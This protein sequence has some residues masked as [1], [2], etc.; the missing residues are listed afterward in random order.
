[1]D[2][3][4]HQASA[5]RAVANVPPDAPRSPAPETLRLYASDWATF[6]T[7]CRLA[8]AAPLPADPADVRGVLELFYALAVAGQ[9]IPPRLVTFVAESFG[10]YL[11]HKRY[12]RTGGAVRRWSLGDPDHLISH[13]RP[14]RLHLGFGIVSHT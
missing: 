10:R 1:M 6:V 8:R 7:G 12:L 14:D 9:P 13:H 5:D 2:A 11:G 4:A 3:E